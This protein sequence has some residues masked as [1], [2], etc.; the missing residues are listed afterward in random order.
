VIAH[1]LV[2]VLPFAGGWAPRT[3]VKP[4]QGAVQNWNQTGKTL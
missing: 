4:Q 2:D 1:F 3:C